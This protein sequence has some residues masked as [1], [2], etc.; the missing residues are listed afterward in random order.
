MSSWEGLHVQKYSIYSVNAQAYR[1][2]FL[3]TTKPMPFSGQYSQWQMIRWSRWFRSSCLT[4]G[5]WPS[6]YATRGMRIAQNMVMPPSLLHLQG[7][8]QLQRVRQLL[9]VLNWPSHPWKVHQSSAYLCRRSLVAWR[10][11]GSAQ[12]IPSQKEVLDWQVDLTWSQTRQ[13]RDRKIV[14]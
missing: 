3:R 2:L 5:C 8:Q 4:G 13:A 1:K 14:R 7:K 6:C 11:E 12:V 10:V 9:A